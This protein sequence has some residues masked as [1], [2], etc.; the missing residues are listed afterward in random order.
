M[1]TTNQLESPIVDPSTSDIVEQLLF[2]YACALNGF[3]R[4][5]NH[6][7]RERARLMITRDPGWE[8]VGLPTKSAV[9]ALLRQH[10]I[11]MPDPLAD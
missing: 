6:R 10:G 4:Y 11:A 5:P 8:R 3:K 9:S 1:S 7:D 2:A